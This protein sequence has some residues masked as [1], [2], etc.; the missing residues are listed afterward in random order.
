MRSNFSMFKITTRIPV[1]NPSYFLRKNVKQLLSYIFFFSYVYF[2]CSPAAYSEARDILKLGE[3]ITDNGPTL[4]SAGGKFELGFFTPMGKSSG[5]RFV[6]IWY[7][8]W[9]NQTVVWVAN[10]DNPIP[11][12]STG[13]FGTD[14]DG[15]LRV[16]DTTGTGNDYWSIIIRRTP[17]KNG[18]VKLMDSGNLVLTDVSNSRVVNLWESFKDPADTFL[19][20]MKMV[21]GLELA[22]WKGRDNP[23]TGVFKFKLQAERDRYVVSKNS[24]EYWVSKS[25]FLSSDEMPDAIDKLLSYSN[26]SDPLIQESRLVM[27]YSGQLQYWYSQ[28]LMLWE[29]ENNCSIYDACGKFGS[30]NIN[31]RLVCKCLP[32]FKPSS[33]EDWK[34]RDFS[35]GC[36]RIS[37]ALS[38]RDKFL[39]LKMMKVT[40]PDKTEFVEDEEECRKLCLDSS[41]CQAYSYTNNGERKGRIGTTNKIN[42]CPIWT[43]EVRNLQ[44]EY[45]G[46]GRDLFVRVAESDIETTARN[47]EPCGT[48]T[49]PYPL[50]TSLN[51]GDTTY[52]SF[53]CNMS[54]GQVS[55]NAPSGNYCV[56]SINPSTRNFFI[57]PND[58]SLND[59]NPRRDLQLNPAL[60]FYVSDDDSGKSSSEVEISWDPPGEPSC[61]SWADCKDWPQST[62]NPRGHGKRCLCNRNFQ[63]NGLNLNCTKESDSGEPSESKVKLLLVVVSTLACVIALTC[64]II[65]IY[66][67]RKKIS[68][69]QANRESNK[70]NRALHTLH[71]ERHVKDLID[72]GEIKEEDEGIDVPFFDMESILIAT[73]SFSDENKLG[74]GG[75]G[76]VYKGTFP[77]GQEIAVK[78]LSSVSGQGL[79]EFKNEVV[80]IAKLQHRNLVRLRGYSIKGDEK[81]LLYEYM[82]NKSLD[83]FIFD[84]KLSVLLDWK[85]RFNI[86]LGIARGL[87]YLHQDSRLRIIHRD[88]KTSN[89]LLDEEMNPKISDFGLARI[90]GGKETGDNTTQVVGTYGYMSPE[91]ALDGQF[92]FKS[93]CYSFGVVL[94]EII[95]GK[96]NTR[97]YQSEKAMSLIGYA[98]RLWVGNMVL[99]LMDQT[100]H[101][102]CNADQFVKCANIALLCVQED[103]NDRPTMSNIVTMLDS[104]TATVPTPKKPAYLP[105]PRRDLSST[106]SS[107]SRLDTHTEVTGSL[108]ETK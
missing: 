93:D 84:Q 4:I 15:N 100:L 71:S 36:T 74:Q 17:I 12:D 25:E 54:S 45:K 96:K 19:P 62:C 80:L 46:H 90:V 8:S 22:S 26:N 37:T 86:I 24:D 68:K 57:R 23:G 79:Q 47:C 9:P 63:W 89:I 107:S 50:S 65:G 20:G 11:K 6:G 88:L 104:E 52:F 33:P 72:S 64:I 55:F 75:Y 91:Y 95:S 85:I 35:G 48:N 76:P 108:G 87:L 40:D 82:P 56:T 13:V 49:I 34:A 32:G 43:E 103:P 42:L 53:Y 16:S 70:R 2:L 92:S 10:R 59:K 105:T 81:I 101:E 7:H 39:S 3:K 67:W 58:K 44:E 60:P 61:S 27:D 94:L 77:G 5:I 99:D 41:R 21:E 78:R 28:F 1:S 106:A 38:S 30:C 14:E 31:N 102:V 51:C 98:W 97:F 83:S 29:P 73:D 66:I 69:T 18:Y